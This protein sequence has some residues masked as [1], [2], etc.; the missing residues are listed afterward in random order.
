[1]DPELGELVRR[2]RAVDVVDER[3]I[4]RALG[5]PIAAASIV[6][7]AR[8]E[9]DR[10]TRIA[11]A[12]D[13]RFEVRM[14]CWAPGQSSA[15]H[16]HGEAACGFRVLAGEATETRLDGPDRRL[17]AGAV[18]SVRGTDVH[19]VANRGDGPLITLHVY[20]PALPVDEASSGHGR[21]V[22]IVGGGF[23]GAALAA[24]LL[25]TGRP[26]WRIT[27]IERADRVGPGVAYGTTDP[28][29]RLN[30][31]AGRMGLDPEDPGGFVRWARARGL[32]VTDGA[33]VPR[34]WYGD[35]LTDA[36][37][38][39]IRTAPGKLRLVRGTA[40]GVRGGRAG[41]EVVLADGTAVPADDV[42]L[43]TGHLAPIVP[44]AIPDALLDDPRVVR[45]PWASGA[46][47]IDRDDR[48]LI[49]GTGLTAVDVILTLRSRRHR[50]LVLAVSPGGRWPA[51]HLPDPATPPI[52]LEP[53]I[54]API[55][56][57]VDW[58]RA[59]VA[60]QAAAGV[61]FQ[62][63]VDAIRPFV[64]ALWAALP[65]EE[66]ARFV[67]RYRRSWERVRHRAAAEAL[68]QLE[69]WRASGALVTRAATLAR[70]TVHGSELVV[71]LART[72]TGALESRAVDRVV[73]CTGADP[74]L[75]RGGNPIVDDRSAAGEL[76]RDP[77]RLGAAT[78]P[79]GRALDAHGRAVPDLWVLGGAR[80]PATWESTSVPE[81]AVQ[82]RDLALALAS[83]AETVGAR[84][85]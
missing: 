36:L 85:P 51:S 2:L 44:T 42:V 45:D 77:L 80:R 18:S 65:P 56:A 22:V 7:H 76:T 64:P 32:A 55:D 10:Y 29:H 15:L 33:L 34:S 61:P 3:A 79:D 63:V 8:F 27:V 12:A 43:A 83:R 59:T 53:P 75:R 60:R 25:A 84:L 82:A 57:V 67:A 41:R 1:M 62:R 6:R 17:A 72:G 48:V 68:G 78:D 74:D 30:V 66:R 23:C 46:L 71:T 5:A 28:V 16:A 73:L 50:G 40:T 13:P 58:Y 31:P 26:G 35:Y 21:R 81:L 20:A 9:P 19:Q 49:V 4:T 38:D 69:G 54:G 24:H 70:V 11:L 14:L 47:R 37:A 39:A 52:E